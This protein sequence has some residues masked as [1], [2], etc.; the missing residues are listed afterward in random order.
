MFAE[1]TVVGTRIYQRSDIQA[2]ID[3]VTTGR[4]DAR[5]RQPGLTR[6]TTGSPPSTACGAARA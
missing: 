2:A 6:C 4:L 3:L 1:L 5:G